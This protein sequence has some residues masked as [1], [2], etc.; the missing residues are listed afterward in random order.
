LAK[1]SKAGETFRI[2]LTRSART[3]LAA[4]GRPAKDW[5]DGGTPKSGNKFTREKESER[6]I[7]FICKKFRSLVSSRFGGMRLVTRAAVQE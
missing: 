7:F 2:Y 3:W 1:T 6:K 5:S 4:Y